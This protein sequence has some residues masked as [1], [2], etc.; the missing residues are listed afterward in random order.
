[1]YPL[2]PELLNA[3]TDAL[4]TLLS[5]PVSCQQACQPGCISA[6]QGAARNRIHIAPLPTFLLQC[7]GRSFSLTAYISAQPDAKAAL[8]AIATHPSCQRL[9]MARHSSDGQSVTLRSGERLPTLHHVRRMC[10]RLMDGASLDLKL[11][12]PRL[13]ELTVPA[14][15]E[16]LAPIVPESVKLCCGYNPERYRPF[17]RLRRLSVAAKE[18]ELVAP[19]S[20]SR[21]RCVCCSG[22]LVAGSIAPML[23][24]LPPCRIAAMHW[25]VHQQNC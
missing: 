19:V 11:H 16:M 7:G 2:P 3:Y 1:M 17:P 20:E 4:H 15:P 23:S 6:A 18:L 9:D 5:R 22:Q 10:V 13:E 21:R 12:M 25:L 14:V 8:A 24:S